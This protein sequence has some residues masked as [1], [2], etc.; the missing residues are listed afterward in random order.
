MSH[1]R[2][3]SD[4]LMD[5]DG[6]GL[7][8]ALDGAIKTPG[9]KEPKETT[10]EEKQKAVEKLLR[11]GFEG[12]IEPPAAPLIERPKGVCTDEGQKLEAPLW[13]IKDVL[14]ERGVVPL[15]P[16]MPGSHAQRLRHSLAG[17]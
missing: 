15:R 6:R 10:P 13:L 4:F 9:K 8:A 7:L 12:D 3:P 1:D 5:G 11:T 16:S 2:D 14:P 17:R